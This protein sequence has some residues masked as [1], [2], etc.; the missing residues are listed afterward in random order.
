MEIAI[1]YFENAK[2]TMIRLAKQGMW[3]HDIL[4]LHVARRVMQ[5]N[6]AAIVCQLI[7]GGESFKNTPKSPYK[8]NDG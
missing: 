4:K 2:A 8:Q 6:L 7:E 5:I 1:K 3:R